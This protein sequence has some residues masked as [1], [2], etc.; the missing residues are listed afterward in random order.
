MVLVSALMVHPRKA[1]ALIVTFTVVWRL[2]T[3][4]ILGPGNKFRRAILGQI[5][6]QALKAYSRL[7]AQADH[8]VTVLGYRQEMFYRVKLHK[9]NDSIF[10]KFEQK[11]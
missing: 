2:V 3:Q 10:S 11:L 9:P 7:K 8:L 6:E 4:I 5:V 1:I